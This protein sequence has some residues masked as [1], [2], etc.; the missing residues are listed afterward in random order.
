MISNYFLRVGFCVK[1]LNSAVVIGLYY[2]F[3]TTFSIGPSYLFLIRALVEEG[4]ETK[5]AATT[6]FITGQLMMFISIYYAPLHLAL[7]RPHTITVLTLPYLFFNFVH[8]NDKHYYSGG[9]GWAPKLDSGYKNP[10]SIRNFRIYKVFL[11]HLFFQLLNPFLFPSSILIRL[12]NVYL[13]RSNNKLFFLTSS[14]VGWFIGQIFLMNCIGLILVWLQ[15]KNSI[16]LIMRLDKYTLLQLR[17]YGGQIFVVFSFVIV[18][19]CLGRAPLPYYYIEEMK[20]YDDRDLQEVKGAIAAEREETNEEEEEVEEGEEGEEG[21]DLT[22]SIFEDI[23]VY[24]FRKEENTNIEKK[25]KLA[26][27]EKSLVT[28]LFDYQ[29]WNRPLRYIKNDNFERVVRDENSQFFFQV[30]QSDG[31]KR[32]SFTY[33]PHLSTFLK[34]MEKKMDLFRRDKTSYNENELSNYWSS[35]NKE[36]GNKLIN[37][38]LKRAKMID[39]KSNQFC[40]V[41]VFE[42]RIR[43]SD[44]QSQTKYLIKIYDPFLNGRVRGESQKS[45]LPFITNETYTTNDILINKIHGL[46]LSINSNDPEFEQKIDQFDRKLL[47]SE[48]GFFFNLISKFSEKSVSSLNFDGLYLFPEHEQVKIYSEEKKRKSNILLDAIRTDPRNNTIFN[49]KLCSEINEIS[50]QVP[51]WSYDLVDELDVLMD[52]NPKESQI[53]SPKADR[54]VIYDGNIDID[55]NAE[56]DPSKQIALTDYSR[57]Q[58]YSREIIRGSMRAQRRKTVTSKLFQGTAHSPIFFEIIDDFFGKLFYDLSL[59]WKESFRKPGTDNSEFLEYQRTMEEVWEA[60]D[61]DDAEIRL[62]QIEEAWESIIYGLIIRSFVLI[63]QSMF[64]RNILIPSLIIIKNIIRILLFQKPEWSEDIR[65]WRR[66]IHIYCTYQGVPV[67][68][69]DLPINW[70]SDGIQIRILCPFVLKPWHSKVRSTEKKKDPRKQKNFWFLTG[71]GTQVESYI[72]DHVPYPFLFLR[73][74]FKKITKHLK[75]DFKKRFFKVLKVLNERRKWF[76]IVIVE[77][78]NW[79][80]KSFLFRFKKMDFKK[81]DELGES[82]KNS[83]ISKSNPMIEESPVIIQSIHWT[84]SSFTEKRIKDLNV[85]TNTILKQIEKMKEEE[86]IEKMKEEEQIKKMKEE[87]KEEVITLE[88]NLNS[89]KTTDVAKR[90]ELLKNSLQILKRRN[91]RLIRKSFCF[92]QIFMGRLYIE[93]IFSMIRRLRFHQQRFLTYLYLINKIVNVNKYI[94]KKN[95]NE[96]R[97]YKTNASII[98]FIS[99]IDKFTDMNS[100]NSCDVSSLSQAYVFFKLSQ[101]QV[102][103]GYK[104]KFRPILE[105]HGRSFFLTNEIKDYF[106]RIQGGR[107]NYKLRHKNRPDSRMNQWTNWLKL[108]YQYAL[109]QSGWSRL[110]AQ[111]WRKRIHEHRVAQKKDLVE[112]DS[113]QKNPLIFY[114]KQEV[115]KKL[116]NKKKIKKQY[117]YDLFSY[118]YLNYNYA[119]KKKSNIDGYKSPLQAKGISSNYNIPQNIKELFDIMGDS[120]IQNYI[121]ENA[122]D[123][124]KNRNRKYLNGLGRGR[125]V[126]RKKKAI[127]NQKLLTPRFGFFSKLSAYKKNPWILPINFFFL[128]FY[129]NKN[130]TDKVQLLVEKKEYA[131]VEDLKSY[132][133]KYYPDKRSRIHKYRMDLRGERHFLLD[134]YMGFY[135]DCTN[136]VEDAIMNNFNYLCLLLRIQNLKKFFIISIKK[137][138]LDL[139]NLVRL[140]SKDTSYTECRDTEDLRDN[141]MFFIEPIRISIKKNYEQFFIYQI[142]SISLRYK[143]KI[144]KRNSKKS[145]VNQKI[146]EKKDQNNY[147][148][149]VPENLLSTRRRREL[150]ILICL[151][152]RNRKTVHRK[153]RNDNDKKRKNSSQVLTKNKDL[154]SDT[155]KLLNLKF[156]LWPNYRFED[157]ACMNRY[158]FDTHNGSRFSILRIH[159][160]P[161][162]KI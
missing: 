60:E 57:E 42:N 159:M 95:K 138:D 148:L 74:I 78:D 22:S 109:P 83:T 82:K 79:D 149:L 108:H 28:T 94:Y 121:A 50:K 13:F 134:K 128:Q 68:H 129:G 80:I 1:I 7:S 158:W 116:K 162:L 81:I 32:I 102:S 15:Q 101:S 100:K 139:E 61:K 63:F 30:C 27:L 146:T 119:D 124:E 67:S 71:Y 55:K 98:P 96:Q 87:K 5:I 110:V 113:S 17:N 64:R 107:F 21:E 88:I 29:K 140:M 160:Y 152:P 35:I 43:L 65:D 145:R 114:K 97:V 126:E 54:I 147:D 45:F 135:S 151:N 18:A 89:T 90:L 86:Q 12:M 69:K 62:R 120:F 105:S 92:F 132:L 75:K 156:F 38:F 66:E 73:P 123:M 23:T 112:Y 59:I 122:I 161:R 125:N 16:K 111:K 72:D 20:Q 34:I 51:R 31:K 33:P 150:R 136:P 8:K 106:L 155:K 37:E 76:R 131:S 153:T 143:R 10:N 14:F 93:N 6:G 47:L 48:I 84:K 70:F 24:L 46:L 26:P 103:N 130:I 157:L 137:T 104:Y 41:D 91:V 9:W 85:K 154:D 39:T 133:S 4:S 25:K 77:I 142:T 49:R 52:A 127:T 118:Q 56:P 117:G 144:A 141:L 58:D 2:G 99:I 115:V 3:L 19:H 36:K 40:P 53:R 44:D 11:N